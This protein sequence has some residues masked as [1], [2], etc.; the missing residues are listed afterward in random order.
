MSIKYKRNEE[1]NNEIKNEENKISVFEQKTTDISLTNNRLM[2]NV[3]IT[4]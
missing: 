3:S 4:V 1:N 2:F